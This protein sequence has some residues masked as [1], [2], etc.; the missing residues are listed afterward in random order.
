MP[1]DNIIYTTTEQQ[2]ENLKKQG[3]IIS[4]ENLARLALQTY[5]YSNL[6][7]SYR[8]PY[9]IIQQEKKIFRSG[10]SWEQIYSLYAFDKDLRNAVMASMIDLE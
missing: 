6:I 9:T 8:D 5:G 4:D 1:N 2:I 10:T 7:K 3:L